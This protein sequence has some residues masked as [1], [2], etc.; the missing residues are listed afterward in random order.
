MKNYLTIYSEILESGHALMGQ[1]YKE[2]RH[3]FTE[4]STTKLLETFVNSKATGS[5]RPAV[6]NF[7]EA[8]VMNSA[9]QIPNLHQSVTNSNAAMTTTTTMTGTIKK[10]LMQ[11]TNTTTT[12]KTTT[13]LFNLSNSFY[14]SADIVEFFPMS[15]Q[16]SIL[17]DNLNKENNTN[18]N[19]NN[20]NNSIIADFADH[21]LTNAINNHFL[22]LNLSQSSSS[23][24]STIQPSISA[25]N[26]S[27][28][29]ENNFNNNG[30]N[31]KKDGKIF[32]E[33]F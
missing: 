9:N 33:N 1:V 29:L 10:D 24:L 17:N 28:I 8:N 6:I 25:S 30:S 23:T 12:T 20:N 4:L 11:S 22:P 31:N 21:H 19:N 27:T 15:T 16:S 7:E 32:F 3:N 14:P 26:N 13:N 2:F 18:D 5:N